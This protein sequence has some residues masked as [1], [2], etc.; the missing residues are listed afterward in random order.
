MARNYPLTT[1]ILVISDSRY[2][3]ERI[4]LFLALSHGSLCSKGDSNI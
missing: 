3:V 1:R 4:I 2:R